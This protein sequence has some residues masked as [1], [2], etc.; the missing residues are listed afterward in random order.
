MTDTVIRQVGDKEAQEIIYKLVGYAFHPSPPLLDKKV[1]A[2][3]IE[4]RMG[5]VHFALFEDDNAVACAACAPMMQNVRGALHPMSGVYDVVTHPAARRSGYARRLMASL[6]EFMQA[7]EFP[8]TCLYPFRESFYDKLGY[9]TFPHPRL[10]TIKPANLSSLLHKELDGEVEM[11]LMSTQLDTCDQFFKEM[12]QDVHGMGLF[13]N[14]IKNLAS[15]EDRWL[16]LARSGSC[17]VGLMV[18]KLSGE[19]DLE[20]NLDAVRFYYRN[21]LGRYLLLQWI[22]RHMDQ[23][24]K[25]E[26]LLAPSELP[27]TW[28]EDIDVKGEWKSFSGMGRILDIAAI[29][30]VHVGPGSFSARVHDPFCPW[31]EGIWRFESQDGI[32]HISRGQE[33]DCILEIQGLTALFYGPHHP[34]DFFLRG[35]GDP[36]PEVQKVMRSMFPLQIPYLHEFY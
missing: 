25:A 19:H 22:A 31:N 12:Q 21:P 36:I 5:G 13:V 9:V 6:F 1:W 18:Y 27:E 30:G 15:E 2:A 33:A 35:W 3:E 11:A 17:L 14:R 32:L 23:V 34:G 29:Q 28:L 10:I 26:L 7:E 24:D 16:A 20:L 8:F 4:Q